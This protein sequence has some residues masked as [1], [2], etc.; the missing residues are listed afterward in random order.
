MACGPCSRS[1][2]C[3]RR[4]RVRRRSVGSRGSPCGLEIWK[5]GRGLPLSKT[6]R[7]SAGEAGAGVRQ[8]L[9][10]AS[11]LALSVQTSGP[12]FRMA[13][14]WALVRTPRRA[15]ADWR[16]AGG[17]GRF[18]ESEVFQ[19]R[20]T[21]WDHELPSQGS[22]TP[23]LRSIPGIAVRSGK[24]VEDY[25]SPRRFATP[26]AKRAWKSVRSWTAPVPWR[27]L[28]GVPRRAT[29]NRPWPIIG[30][31]GATTETSRAF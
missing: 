1:M 5:S 21:Y 7:D 24:A 11:P 23:P 10:C 28:S 26:H 25:R 3:R 29:R 18:M 12:P 31:R 14:G 4:A 16:G 22:G 17:E 27:F 6:L 13:G 15:G 9:D 2:N 8:V 20:D 30:S 19:N